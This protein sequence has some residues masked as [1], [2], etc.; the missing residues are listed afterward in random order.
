MLCR[1]FVVLQWLMA[2]HYKGIPL[3][4]AHVEWVLGLVRAAASHPL[5]DCRHAVD[6][7][8]VRHV[9]T[10]LSREADKSLIYA[11]LFRRD[12]KCMAGDKLMFN[13]CAQ[14]WTSRLQ[15]RGD[16]N[17]PAGAVPPSVS[18]REAA[19][20][21]EWQVEPVQEKGI[22]PLALAGWNRAA[23]DFHCTDIDSQVARA[24]GVSQVT[25]S[26]VTLVPGAGRCWGLLGFR[27]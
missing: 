4:V 24:A 20:A 27:V 16:P 1:E 21:L 6:V 19:D 2:A 23:V 15:L 5:R 10:R 25:V 11:V 17:A 12:Y 18:P 14:D 3:S 13:A 22:A 9:A 7:F 26:H 8:D